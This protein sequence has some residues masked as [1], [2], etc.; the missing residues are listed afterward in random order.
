[1]MRTILVIAAVAVGATAVLAQ[2]DPIATRKQAM[3]GVG[4]ATKI[5]S[6]MAK[7]EAPFDAAKAKEILQVYAN[8]ADKMHNYFPENSKSGGETT[9]APTI[10]E[11]NAD[12]PQALRRLGSRHQGGVGA[13]Q[14]RRELQ[15]RLRRTS[16]RPAAAATRPSASRRADP[17]YRSATGGGPGARLSVE[18]Q[19]RMRRALVILLVLGIAGAARLLA[20]DEPRAAACRARAGAG[21]RARPRERPDDVLRRRLHLLPCDA[22]TRTTAR[23]LG[24]GYAAAVALRHLLSCRTSRRTADGIGSWT[25]AQFQRAMRGGVS[26][27]GRHYYPAFPYTSYQRMRR[28]RICAT[29]S[30]ICKTL[31]PVRGPGARPRPAVPLQRPAGRS[32]CG[33]S[34]SSTARLSRPIP[35]SPRAGTA[36]PISSRAPRIA[37]NATAPATRSASSRQGAAIA[38]GPNPEGKGSVPNITPDKTGIGDWTKGDIADVL[39]SGLTPSGDSVGSN[40]VEVV[41]NTSQLAARRPRRNRRVHQVAA[42]AGRVESAAIAA[43]SITAALRMHTM[44]ARPGSSPTQR[45]VCGRSQR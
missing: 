24:G 35:R 37:P 32:G 31:P 3:K 28:R 8:A 42:A 44:V 33:S 36:A 21:R 19:Q 45:T 25:T 34:P 17:G 26:P 29:S 38:G 41:R 10:W 12:V 11:N 5:G 40:M 2:G 23:R 13:D 4:D 30:P 9:A 22:R 6:A 39:S 1:M 18:G 14:R 16:P 15:G 7:G 43:Q 20:P 27:D